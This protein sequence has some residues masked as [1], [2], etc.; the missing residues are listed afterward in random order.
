MANSDVSQILAGQFSKPT[1]TVKDQLI[2]QALGLE[3]LILGSGTK[4]TTANWNTVVAAALKM[5]PTTF[6]SDLQSIRTA[7]YWQL[8]VNTLN[9]GIAVAGKSNSALLANANYLRGYDEETLRVLNIYLEG[10]YNNVFP[11]PP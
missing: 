8:A 3:L 6:K 11:S 2:I 9:T 5:S 4:P 10:R 7:I 1:L